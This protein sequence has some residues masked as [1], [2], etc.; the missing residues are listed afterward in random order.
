MKEL[1]IQNL[2]TYVEMLELKTLEK[3]ELL[4][5]INSFKKL[6]KMSLEFE[7]V[8]GVVELPNIEEK[9]LRLKDVELDIKMCKSIMRRYENVLQMYSDGTVENE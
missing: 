3:K 8:G 1:L 2:K 9:K 4:K 5:D 7:K 6:E